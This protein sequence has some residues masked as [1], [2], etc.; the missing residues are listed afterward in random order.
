MNLSEIPQKITLSR[1][2]NDVFSLD[3]LNSRYNI[4]YGIP[5]TSIQ[6]W[7]TGFSGGIL[8]FE[9]WYPSWILRE[10]IHFRPWQVGTAQKSFSGLCENMIE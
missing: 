10:N 1:G 9:S 4:T 3:H 5:V 2:T 6:K 8:Y 7:D